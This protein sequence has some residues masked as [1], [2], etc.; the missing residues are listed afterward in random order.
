MPSPWVR[1]TLMSPREDKMDEQRRR[2]Q[3][4]ALQGKPR[5]YGC[6]FGMRSS[7]EASRKQYYL[8]WDEVE[9][10]LVHGDVWMGD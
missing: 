8:G 3:E 10:Y 1:P 2:G 9:Y 5:Y 6:H 4:D 7:L